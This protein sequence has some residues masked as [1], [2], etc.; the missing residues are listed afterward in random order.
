MT[1]GIKYE[2]HD[3]PGATFKGVKQRSSMVLSFE[4]IFL[5]A[6]VE[7]AWP[8]AQRKLQQCGVPRA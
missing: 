4:K 7:V 1:V 8:A 5:V 3:F 6:R 2:S